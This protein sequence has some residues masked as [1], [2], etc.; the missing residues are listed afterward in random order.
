MTKT[1]KEEYQG[2]IYTQSSRWSA[3]KSAICSC[4]EKFETR[5]GLPVCPK[6]GGANFLKRN[7]VPEKRTTLS[8]L[9]EVIEKADKHFHARRTEVKCKMTDG[10]I[11]EITFGNTMELKFNLVKKEYRVFNHNGEELFDD[12]A[13]K[14][15]RG[16]SENPRR[17]IKMVST[18]RNFDLYLYAYEELSK[19]RTYTNRS[20]LP[21]TFLMLTKIEDYVDILYFCG[22]KPSTIFQYKHLLNQTETK[23]HKI[24]GVPKYMFK[25]VV[26]QGNLSGYK[27]NKLN[28]LDEEFGG[29]NA[30]TVLQIL[31]EE[32]NVSQLFNLSEIYTL[33]STYGYNDIRKLM[34][35]LCREV[36]LQQG[37]EN[38]SDA[39]TYLRDYVR[40]SKELGL[41]YEKFPK[42][43]KK[44]HDIVSVTYRLRADN[45]K[46]ESFQEVV[47]SEEYQALTYKTKTYS[48]IAPSEP[49]DLILEG[50]SLSHCV[51]SYVNDV[52]KRQCKVLF[53]RPTKA[54][55]MSMLT[56]DVRGDKYI[57]QVKGKRNRRPQPEEIE[58]VQKWAKKVGL[59]IQGY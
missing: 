34:L 32:S 41:D 12:D 30:K 17:F 15:F 48:V 24:V 25:Y 23:P 36:K 45:S 56:I 10:S 35:Y 20:S 3:L 44:E 47:Q 52:I 53:V 54:P 14:F 5:A 19:R 49:N 21:N 42:S 50:A 13:K 16:M 8:P 39:I 59:E 6:C 28:R 43:L 29:N 22:F 27:L 51:A 58:F 4:G 2:G 1:A 11:D 7:K 31:E 40:M 57:R 46:K 18:E 37:I 9:I 55:D 26:K 33:R 38:P